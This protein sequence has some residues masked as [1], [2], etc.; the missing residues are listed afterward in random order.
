[1]LE[2]SS[3]PIDGVQVVRLDGVTKSFAGIRALDDVSCT[4][5]GRT[6]VAIVGANGSGK[7]TLLR[8]IAGVIAADSGTVLILDGDPRSNAV[9]RNVGYTGQD[10]ALDPEMTGIE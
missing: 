9:R 3:T 2:P 8:L 10:L 4:I 7:S 1:M 6:L 5:T